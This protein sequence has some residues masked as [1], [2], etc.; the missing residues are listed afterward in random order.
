MWYGLFS[1]LRIRDLRRPLS[2]WGIFSIRLVCLAR[3]LVDFVE[4][5]VAEFEPI[6]PLRFTGCFE[7][8]EDAPK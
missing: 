2:I 7:R 4:A 8:F 3:H 5:L 6:I 1:F